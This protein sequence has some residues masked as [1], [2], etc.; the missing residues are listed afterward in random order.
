MAT[1]IYFRQKAEQ[2]RR[3]AN[4]LANDKD[5][6]VTALRALA[7]EFDHKAQALESETAAA[8]L[9]G[10]GDDI[11]DRSALETDGDGKDKPAF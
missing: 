3:L 2:C 10:Y 8:L 11:G 5:P 9:I 1:A 7:V 4:G 6:A